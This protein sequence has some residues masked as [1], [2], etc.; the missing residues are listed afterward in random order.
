MLW[1]RAYR[2]KI[3]D[4]HDEAIGRGSTPGSAIETAERNWVAEAQREMRSL[5]II[6]ALPRGSVARENLT[7]RLL[8]FPSHR[9]DSDHALGVQ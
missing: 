1:K 4:G 2:T 3:S 9:T 7:D 6:A 5:E 8:V